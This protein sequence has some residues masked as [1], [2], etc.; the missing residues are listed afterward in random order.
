MFFPIPSSE[1][2]KSL[3]FGSN[4]KKNAKKKLTIFH[5]EIDICR[6]KNLFKI[7]NRVYSDT[8]ELFHL[9]DET[10]RI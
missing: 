2:I 3:N 9:S 1:F 6:G 7:R 10:I 8:S 4:L 5:I